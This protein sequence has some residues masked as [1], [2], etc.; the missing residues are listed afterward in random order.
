MTFT[1]ADFS[2]QVPPTIIE[3]YTFDGLD[4]DGN[5]VTPADLFA[6]SK[7]TLINIWATWCSPCKRELPELGK[8]AKELEEK[9]CRVIGICID[10]VDDETIGVAKELLAEAGCEYTNIRGWKSFDEDMPVD[11]FPSTIFVDSE[12]KVIAAMKRTLPGN[13]SSAPG[14]T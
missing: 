6:D 5:E 9:G 4:L 11:S 14:T 3:E 13:I 2:L 1:E 10:A 7:V 8:L 12:S